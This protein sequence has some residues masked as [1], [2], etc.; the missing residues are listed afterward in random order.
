LGGLAFD[1]FASLNAAG[2]DAHALAG[3]IDLRFDRLQVYI[4][5]TTGRVVG[6]GDIVSEL[7]TFAAEITF[8]CHDEL[9]QS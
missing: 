2:A 6:V 8:G 5:A 3:A 9:L 7:R 4:P 1:D